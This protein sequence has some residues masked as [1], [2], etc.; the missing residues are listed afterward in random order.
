MATTK[1]ETNSKSVDDQ[2]A[3]YDAKI[4][5]LRQSQLAGF[6]AELETVAARASELRQLIASIKGTPIH[7][8]VVKPGKKPK[9][10][11]PQGK[12]ISPV[13]L[14]ELVKESG[15][16][17]HLRGRK[18]DDNGYDMA[19]AKKA[20]EESGGK[21]KFGPKGPWPTIVPA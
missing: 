5:E 16:V 18:K 10:D 20:V 8:E 15:G 6:E 3:E 11:R 7:P 19:S 4:K 17:L 1:Q 9:A 14:A 21:F 12:L 2:I 13:R